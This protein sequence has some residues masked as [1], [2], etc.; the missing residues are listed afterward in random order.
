MSL[1]ALLPV[2]IDKNRLQVEWDYL[3]NTKIS[4]EDYDWRIYPDID[5]F[6]TYIKSLIEHISNTID[7]TPK[8]Y[9]LQLTTKLNIEDKD[10]LSIVHR[11]DDRKS[12]ITIPIYYNQNETAMFYD[13]DPNIN[14][15][16]FSKT[17]KQW[18]NKPVKLARYSNDHPTLVNV[19]QLH[20]V[21][22]MDN[23]S[24]RMLLQ[25]SFDESFQSIIDRNPDIWKI[26]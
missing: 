7:L 4:S 12:C 22:I 23:T 19:N 17:R 3:Y 1:A 24:Q 21:R 18:P 2:T 25:M 13:D 16:L 5:Y 15:R 20:N 10:S 26:I 8:N 14:W 6:P 11:D 9:V